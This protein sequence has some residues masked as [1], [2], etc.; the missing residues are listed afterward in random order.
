[1][2]RKYTENRTT[3]SRRSKN[4]QMTPARTITL[5][6]SAMNQSTFV[7]EAK[8]ASST[9]LNLIAPLEIKANDKSTQQLDRR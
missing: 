8:Y 3:A 9:G 1:L 5:L 2:R 4:N 6:D 7:R